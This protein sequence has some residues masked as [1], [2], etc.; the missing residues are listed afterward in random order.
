MQLRV[1]TNEEVQAFLM[2]LDTDNYSEVMITTHEAL[3]EVGATEESATELLDRRPN[4]Y[5]TTIRI[6]FAVAPDDEFLN[7][8]AGRDND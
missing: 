1:M 5:D 4:S 3:A 2:L 7:E 8:L 6:A